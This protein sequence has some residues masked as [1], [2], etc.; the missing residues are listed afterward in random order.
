MV[1]ADLLTE[2]DLRAAMER[3]RLAQPSSI[4]Y[5]HPEDHKHLKA[6][7]GGDPKCQRCAS[8]WAVAEQGRLGW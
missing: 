7:N 3:M 4:R 2:A 6:H 8:I 5:I 1:S